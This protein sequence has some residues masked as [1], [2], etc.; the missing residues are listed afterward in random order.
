MLGHE[1]GE[2]RRRVRAADEVR[3]GLLHHV[4]EPARVAL[5][6]PARSPFLEPLEPV[7]PH[8]LEQ[9]IA[10]HAVAGLHGDERLVHERG[11]AVEDVLRLERLAR[12]DRLRRV[13]REAA[14]EHREPAQQHLLPL[15]EQ[16]VAPF[17][18]R[19]ERA[20]PR[21]RGAAAAREQLE[22]VVQPAGDLLR[23]QHAHARGGQLDRERDA[24]EATADLGHR[25]AV[26]LGERER[27][28]RRVRPLDEQLDRLGHASGGTSHAVSLATPSASRLV[29]RIM[30]RGQRRSSV[31]AISA[32]ASTRCSQLSSTRSTGSS[33]SSRRS[34]DAAS[35][36]RWACAA[37]RRPAARPASRRPAARGR[38]RRCVRSASAASATLR[39]EAGLAAPAG[40]GQRDESRRAEQTRELLELAVASDELREVNRNVRR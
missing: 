20:M 26:R 36:A 39:G 10:R 9:P 31:S 32:A 23:R 16:P 17:H 12:A 3:L 4:E 22:C 29:A 8:G 21:Q 25:V 38:S 15:A 6:A 35:S 40:A 24:V 30:R 34:P 11:D 28:Q 33:R 37:R 5:L 1:L 13:E 14:E 18:R 7:L 2:Q 27:G 19:A